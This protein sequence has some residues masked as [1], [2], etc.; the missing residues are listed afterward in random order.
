MGLKDKCLVTGHFYPYKSNPWNMTTY[1]KAS[2]IS[3]YNLQSLPSYKTMSKISKPENLKLND[4]FLKL[5][6]HNP[7]GYQEMMKL[8]NYNLP[9]PIEGSP[10]FYELFTYYSQVNYSPTIVSHSSP[11]QT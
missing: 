7:K 4:E 5:R 10:G 3:K 1:E 11:Q 8:I 9:L 2:Y 6:Q